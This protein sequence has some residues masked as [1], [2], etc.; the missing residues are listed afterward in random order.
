[1]RTLKSKDLFAA[2]RVVKEVGIKDEMRRMAEL[3]KDGKIDTKEQ[4]ELGIE[5]VM[6]ILANCGTESAE[7]AFFAFLSLP[8]EIDP[9]ELREMDLE[10]F[11]DQI[12]EL[13]ETVDIDHWR[14]FFHSLAELIKKQN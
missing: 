8:M 12:R 5:L 2:L 9:E 14:G 4:T 13:I 7:Q 10:D 1:M 3:V 11:A 6:N